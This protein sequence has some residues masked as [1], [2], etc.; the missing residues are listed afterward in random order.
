MREAE[1]ALGFYNNFTYYSPR[2]FIPKANALN[3]GTGR[4]PHWVAKSAG[5]LAIIKFATHFDCQGNREV[6][7]TGSNSDKNA[8]NRSMKSRTNRF[9]PSKPVMSRS[10]DASAVFHAG[11]M[12]LKPGRAWRIWRSEPRKNYT[13]DFKLRMVKLA[14]QPE[15]GVAHIIRE[16]GTNDNLIFKWL[17]L[18]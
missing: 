5:A 14:Y 11:W 12:V 18:W 9:S 2:Y 8:N 15:A 13:N 17:R 10:I 7:P 6:M 3:S 4:F 16:H 1:L